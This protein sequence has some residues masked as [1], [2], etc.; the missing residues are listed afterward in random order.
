MNNNWLSVESKANKPAK[1]KIHGVIGG[2]FFEDGVTDEQVE[3]DLEEIRELKANVIDVDLASLGGSTVHGMRIYDLLKGN[4]AEV[5]INITG[6]TASMGAII[7][8]AADPGKLSMSEN[9]QLLFHES[10]GISK[11]TASQLESDA[12]LMRNF[13]SQAEV[14]IS[15]RSGMSKK[16]AK[17]LLGEN[18]SEGVFMLPKEAKKKG[19]VD[20]IFKP[21][22]NRM[23]ASVT[24]EDLNKFK[25]KAKFNLKNKDMK[26]DLK[27]IAALVLGAF[28]AFVGA[29]TDEEKEEADFNEKAIAKS[30]E[31]IVE[32]LQEQVNTYKKEKEK[33][34]TDLKA[35][36][37]KAQA[38]AINPRGGDADL[39]D[40]TPKT[41]ADKAADQF[42]AALSESDK[43]LMTG[44]KE[45]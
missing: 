36:L 35:E 34:I 9:A 32:S 6:W 27:A 20:T 12:I 17:E 40:P 15:R 16:E 29:S 2:G 25:I 14:I 3:R 45:D 4:S 22:N 8:Q 31:V 28:N 42:K 21:E 44:K 18:N 7:A 1:I 11:G 24:Q 39:G 43:M 5:N 10:R 41:D 38:N 26:F 13:N 30:T 23:A 19:L 37:V 33:E